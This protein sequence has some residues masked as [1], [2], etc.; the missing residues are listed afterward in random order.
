ME[1]LKVRAGGRKVFGVMEA[2]VCV[3]CRCLAAL[4]TQAFFS[5]LKKKY[6][7][8]YRWTKQA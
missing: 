6:I 1:G 8:I 4:F 5:F 2:E 3:G 7:Y